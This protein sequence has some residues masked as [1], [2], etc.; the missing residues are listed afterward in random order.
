M[1]TVGQVK[2]KVIHEMR[3]YSNSGE[4]TS[5]SDNKDY[6][7][8][9]IPMINLYQLEFAS[10]TNKITRKYE[11]SHNMPDNLLGEFEQENAVHTDDDITY[12]ALGARAYSFQVSGTGTAYI[13]EETDTDVWTLRDTVS[14]STAKS[15]GYVTYKGYT[16]ILDTENNARIRFSG[17]YRYLYRW[18][19]LFAENFVTEDEIPKYEPYV[20]YDL[21]TN[22]YQL[23]RID[24]TY[25]YQIL[26]DYDD[27]RYENYDTSLKRIFFKW[28][29]K[30]EFVVHYYAY[31]T[32]IDNAP[33]SSIDSQDDVELDIAEE[34][35]PALVHK[36]ASTLLS[37]ENAYMSDILSNASEL[38]ESRVISNSNYHQGRQGLINNS[39]W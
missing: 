37:D 36:I 25:A 38:S 20:P 17:D 13:E 24:A 28:N 4:V 11:I 35:I 10:S 6:L 9:I 31:P 7:L 22:L 29:V 14:F 23:N 33:E 12:S 1:S 27:Y 15:E 18:V 26:T 30:A 39:N 2:E 21:P 16:G 34:V 8:S 19:G 32:V 5:V 3:E